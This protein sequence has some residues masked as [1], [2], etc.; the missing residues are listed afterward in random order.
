MQVYKDSEC[1]VR[2]TV[3]LYLSYI[4]DKKKNNKLCSKQ[5]YLDAFDVL[6]G[7]FFLCFSPL[8]L[9]SIHGGLIRGAYCEEWV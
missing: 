5:L 8:S 3:S 7:F 1:D 6:F 9:I 2:N 4:F